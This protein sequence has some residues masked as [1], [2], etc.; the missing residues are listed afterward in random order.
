M[1]S[2]GGRVKPVEEI[3]QTSTFEKRGMNESVEP[4]AE[5]REPDSTSQYGI[6]RPSKKQ[7][8]FF[9]KPDPRWKSFLVRDVLSPFRVAV[10][11]I[12]F[13][14]G[15]NVAGPANLL[16]FWNLTESSFLA[17]PPYH[18]TPS[19][20]GYSNFAF[21][22][23]GTIGLLTAGPFSDWVADRATRKN[24]G[25]REAEM[26]LPALIP[27]FITT[28]L[29]VIIGGVGY[30]RLWPW[31]VILVFG[32]G[33]TGLSVTT[34]PTIAIA[35][36]VDCYKPIAGEIMVVATVIKNT[37]GFSMSYWVAPLAAREGLIT[38][39]MVEFALTIGPM[40]LALPLYFF[41]KRLRA[42]TR[43]S[44]VHQLSEI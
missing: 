31:P 41:G 13:W 2:I 4:Q 33:L 43:D 9:R 11:P 30:Q 6:G 12:V 34:V 44:S 22:V 14:A 8:G 18:F 39:A 28:A 23:G 25:V 16:L 32:Y 20:V 40:L 29:G 10:Y 38:P 3:A 26:R 19:G 35:Y 1:Q 42:M 7:F 36:A 17:A 37:C 5:N 24:N 15:L 27:F 21:F